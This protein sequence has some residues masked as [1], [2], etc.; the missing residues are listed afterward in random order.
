MNLVTYFIKSCLRLTKSSS[1][2]LC[3]NATLRKKQILVRF[4][5]AHIDLSIIA[6]AIQISQVW[7]L[8]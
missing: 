4:D 5:L 7:M 6:N 8:K 3:L 2:L 1:Y